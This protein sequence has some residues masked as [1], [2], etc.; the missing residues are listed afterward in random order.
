MNLNQG[1]EL[2]KKN[3]YQEAL[4]Y[5]Q[6][7]YKTE[8]ETF[9]EWAWYFY[10]KT[11]AKQDQLEDAIKVNS[12]LIK[13]FP[14]FEPNINLYGWNLNKH[15][16]KKADNEEQLISTANFIVNITKQE[17]YSAFEKTVFDV[18]KF[19]K[20]RPSPDFNKILFWTE[21][22]NPKMLSKEVFS[23][24][25][26]HGK[27]RELASPL[28]SWY[29]HRIKALF[30]TEQYENCVQLVQEALSSVSSF[31][32]NNDIWFRIK[33]AVSISKLGNTDSAIKRLLL[34]SREKQH[35]T[36]YQE[37]FHLYKQKGEFEKALEMGSY[38]LLERSGEFKHK[39]KLL[40]HMGTILEENSKPK[41]ALLHYCFVSK[42]RAE[43]NWPVNQRITDRVELLQEKESIPQDI[44]H[45]LIRFWKQTKLKSIPKGT[46]IVKSLIA[47]GKAGF[48]TSTDGED[49]FFRVS[50]VKQ[51]DIKVENKVSFHIINSFDQ[52]K[53]R[54]SKEAV[55][56][57]IIK[58]N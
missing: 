13:K 37:L 18:L 15:I 53:Q 23:F 9:N 42:I 48:I 47:S 8:L 43:N 57:I 11:L 25:D 29:Q 34:I 56:I 33:E 28:E 49:L 20:N 27:K 55:E 45:E 35:W 6:K 36:V 31:H 52:K 58:Q 7:A 54:E 16:I 19:L 10:C 40:L 32:Y 22:L 39:I 21:K 44:K 30:E 12:F 4:P 1:I 14:D 17:R 46:G 5:F 50:N 41:E 38:S 3:R 24:T 51:R 26:N 2:A